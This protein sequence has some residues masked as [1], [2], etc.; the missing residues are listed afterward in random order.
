MANQKGFM[1]IPLIVV[2]TLILVISLVA[3]LNFTLQTGVV[4]QKKITLQ[5]DLYAMIN[6]LDSGKLYLDTALKY[7]AYQA[8]YDYGLEEKQDANPSSIA[9]KISEKIKDNL[10]KYTRD[11]YKFLSDKYEVDLPSYTRVDSEL[12]KTGSVITGL[13]LQAQPSANLKIERQQKDETAELEKSG[14]L[15][16][17]FPYPVVQIMDSLSPEKLKQK[18]NDLISKNWPPAISKSIAGCENKAQEI[19]IIDVLNEKAK[20][21]TGKTFPSIPNAIDG[22]GADISSRIQKLQDELSNKNIEVRVTI[23]DAKADIKPVGAC[24]EDEKTDNCGIGGTFTYTKKC[25][26]NYA[27]SGKAKIFITDKTKYYPVKL[28][29]GADTKILFKELAFKTTNSFVSG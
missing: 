7:S 10:N 23:E 22:F 29:E 19:K 18:A 1:A 2:F 9:V 3:T 5:Q 12:S 25:S 14:K 27:Y 15:D 4:I 28:T 16:F 21:N 20:E 26:F 24:Q 11:K 8:A 6:A 13:I 17:D